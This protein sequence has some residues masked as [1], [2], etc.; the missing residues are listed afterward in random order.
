M[1]RMKLLLTLLFAIVLL[2]ACGSNDNASAP[3]DDQDQQSEEQSPATEPEEEIDEELEEAKARFSPLGDMPIP[4][5]NPQTDDKIAL[6]QM[7]YYDER[8]SGDN[9]LSCASCHAPAAGYADGLPTFIG[10][11]GAQGPRNSPSIINA[12][13]YNANFWDGRAGSLEEQALGPIS[14]D[15]EM[16]QDLDELVVELKAIPGYVSEFQ[17][18]FN[19]EIT[20]ENIAKAI[21]SFERTIVIKD[22][23]FDR[24]LA[25]DNDALSDDAKE[26]MKLY[27]G[28]ANCISCHA[29]PLLSDNNYHNLGIEGDD[30]RYAITGQESD[31]GAFRTPGLRGVAH[32]APY[33]HDGSLATL[34]DVVEFYNK[35]GGNHPN[36]SPL[37]SPLNLTDKEIDQLV[38]FLESMSGDI[39]MTEKPELP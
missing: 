3:A 7:L 10:I 30:G 38:A 36:K 23:A 33:M 37:I 31:K 22:T 13:Y 24:F 2:A 8:L 14:S 17:K 39:P 19:E 27:V 32:T 29:G 28:K 21:A 12:G 11:G 1:K 5:D 18:V 25:G 4:E 20:I 6:G 26:G 16:G 15:I 35:G 34:R 9:S